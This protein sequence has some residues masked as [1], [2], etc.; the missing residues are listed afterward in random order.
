MHF[1]SLLLATL[2]ATALAERQ[3]CSVPPLTEEQKAVVAA[4]AAEEDS[5][6][7]TR[8]TTDVDVYFHVVAAGPTPEEGYIPVRISELYD[9]DEAVLTIIPRM[10]KWKLSLKS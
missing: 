8:T 1:K 2:S 10:R 3:R 5:T 7:E 6:V 4:I 9:F